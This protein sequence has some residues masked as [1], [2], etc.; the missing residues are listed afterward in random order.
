VNDR[1]AASRYADALLQAAREM[2]AVEPLR[3]ELNS[4]VAAMEATPEL[5]DFLARPDLEMEQKEQALVAALGGRVSEVLV[6]LLR[7]LLEHQRGQEL[8]AVGEVYNELADDAEGILRAEAHTA[9]TLTAEERAR[10]TAALAH[11]TGKQVVLTETLDPA[12]W[13]ECG[14]WWATTSSTAAPPGA[15]VACGRSCWG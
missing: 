6:S 1:R 12:C 9:V 2:D 5:R 11:L 8:P 13:P 4:L 7:V 15:W 14:S 10:L 3:Q